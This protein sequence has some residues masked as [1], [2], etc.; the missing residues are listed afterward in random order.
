MF[1][2]TMVMNAK[3]ATAHFFA[4]GFAGMRAMRHFGRLRSARAALVVVDQ[5]LFAAL[6]IVVINC[7]LPFDPRILLPPPRQICRAARGKIS[8][9]VSRLR[10]GRNRRFSP[11]FKFRRLKMTVPFSY[12]FVVAHMITITHELKVFWPVIT[13]VEVP[14]MDDRF[15]SGKRRD[16]PQQPGTRHNPMYLLIQAS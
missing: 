9:A 7:R 8:V 11:R 16:F 10:L 13:R 6:A 5:V 3:A 15:L 2:V 1:P 4:A 12:R 14:V